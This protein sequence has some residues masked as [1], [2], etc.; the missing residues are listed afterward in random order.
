MPSRRAS[1]TR[2]LPSRAK[3]LTLR[4]CH[5]ILAW[6]AGHTGRHAV[7]CVQ[8]CAQLHS[9]SRHRT[10]EPLSALAIASA[11]IQI[12]D[13]S[14][15]VVAKTREVYLF[16]LD[17][18]TAAAEEDKFYEG[19]KANLE[20]LMIGLNT[21][22]AQG[23]G[24]YGS[25]HLKTPDQQLLQLAKESQVVAGKLRDMINKVKIRE[26]GTRRTALGQ[27]FRSVIQQKNIT[28]L[29]DK[30][31]GIRKQIDTTVLL[32]LRQ[33]MEDGSLVQQSSNNSSE[34]TVRKL[35]LLMSIQDRDWKPTEHHDLSE[36]SDHLRST[37]EID[38]EE[39]FF[40]AIVGRLYFADL[41]DRYETIPE[42]HQ[43]TFQWIFETSSSSGN[44]T[45]TQDFPE[46]LSATDGKNIFWATGKP[47][48]G[49][50]TLMKFI[51][52]DQR[53]WNQL[54]TWTEGQPLVKAGFFFWNSG[55]AMQM[56]RMGLLQS[57][58][59]TSLVNDKNTVMALFRHRWQQF[60]G[61]GGGREPFTWLELLKAF[62]TMVREPLTPRKFFFAIDGLDEFDG[63]PK[64]LVNLI[65][66]IA[67]YQHVKMC[68]SSRPWLVFADAFEERPSLRLEQLTNNDIRKY[69]AFFFNTN[70]HYARLSKMEPVKSAS[71]VNEVTEKSAGVF[72]WVYLV[73][74][75]LLDGLS[76]ADRMSDL[77]TRLR[78]LPHGL[79]ELYLKLL[80][81]IDANYS[82]HAC[83]LFRL[84]MVRPRPLLL[85]LY[86]AD[87][88]SDQSAMGDCNQDIDP[89]QMIICQ[90][91]MQRRLVSRCKGFLEVEN[92]HKTPN[93]ALKKDSC[94]GW[95]HRSARDFL[96]SE[97]VW[98]TIVSN[99]GGDDVFIPERHWAN[100]FMGKL[101][102]VGNHCNSEWSDFMWGVAYALRVEQK[103]RVCETQYLDELGRTA[104]LNCTIYREQ[105]FAKRT[106]W[107]NIRKT[108]KLQ[109]FLDFAVWINHAGYVQS[110]SPTVMQE[111]LIHAA[112]F[113]DLWTTIQNPSD[114]PLNGLTKIDNDIVK[115]EGLHT[116]DDVL[117]RE[118]CRLALEEALRLKKKENRKH[119]WS[120]AKSRVFG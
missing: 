105:L 84:V 4:C 45:A 69:V 3:C 117:N 18:G 10:M 111:Q 11:V 103:L 77:L 90:E 15:K 67:K 80:N 37:V 35:E 60:L 93:I 14:C 17:D 27:G 75:S 89:E 88:E 8:P 63:D 62:G 82:K 116:Y 70:R 104:E 42:A 95:I 107:D 92:W 44:S 109:H 19:A 12:V 96:I 55:L 13:F 39:R 108:P 64:D 34:A 25:S 38:L 86:F 113:K 72:L 97:P 115:K 81:S 32:S 46:W 20:D 79:E 43:D 61:F 7:V 100:G 87:N 91:T 101:K 76:N 24:G 59:Y 71:L 68:I 56:S 23:T 53:T 66:S 50:S 78:S 26:D 2:E 85:D 102:S 106:G 57:L 110:K 54:D 48:S 1:G 58:L 6:L 9:S 36:F 31:D 120:R 98:K 40:N 114:F 28:A 47:G 119:R 29:N 16:D 74:Q 65:L 52:N 21:S 49:K 30:L 33:K 118:K 73:V 94:A 51:Y 41:P 83:Q 99:T 5:E 112:L 22:L